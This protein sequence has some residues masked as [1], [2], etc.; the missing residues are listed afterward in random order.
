MLVGGGGVQD[1]LD[2]LAADP[3]DWIYRTAIIS[4]AAEI[5]KKQRREEIEAAAITTAVELGKIMAK[6]LGG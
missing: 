4:K 3:D 1:A 6:V 5:S 2:S